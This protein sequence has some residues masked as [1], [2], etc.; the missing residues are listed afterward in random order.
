MS[1]SRKIAT[2][3]MATAGAFALAGAANAATLTYI[4][5]T[6]GNI[7]GETTYADFQTSFGNVSGVSGTSG[8]FSTGVFAT[9][10]PGVAAEPA[11]GDQGDAFYAI[12]GGGAA[13]FSFAA[14]TQFFSFD[15]GSADDFNSLTLFF[16][17]GGTQTFTGAQLNPPGPATGNQ[18]IAA[19]NGR[20]RINS[21]GTNITSARF[22]S[23]GNSF[24]IDNLAVG[25]IPEPS[26]WAMLILGFGVIGATLRRK[27]RVAFAGRAALV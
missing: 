7:A 8:A 22:S 26:T 17:G 27:S 14:N 19:T 15:L 18:N 25:A 1:F 24:E 16:Q 20:V 6:G 5:G 12:L 9:D 4:G 13:T 3:A 10:V 2:V 23:T 21:F 11:F